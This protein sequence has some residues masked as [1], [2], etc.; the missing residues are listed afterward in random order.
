MLKK[1]YIDRIYTLKKEI[2]DAEVFYTKR[3]SII[4]DYLLIINNLK[5]SMTIITN[6]EKIEPNIKYIQLN[7]KASEIEKVFTKIGELTNENINKV[8][9]INKSKS[10]LIQN[11]MEDHTN[12]TENEILL[13]IN[14]LLSK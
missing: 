10:I 4:E 12:M 8:A 11:C 7:E 9:N 6:N 2:K 3:A 1:L 14:T 5:D 13:E